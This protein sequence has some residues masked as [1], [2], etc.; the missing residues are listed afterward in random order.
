MESLDSIALDSATQ[1]NVN[2]W[3]NEPYDQETKAKIRELLNDNPQQIVDSFYTN[4]AFGT[5]GLRG[6][7]GVGTNRVNNY[8]VR[9]ATQGLA[10]YINS[11]PK[12][13]QEFSVFIGYDSRNQSRT[14]AEESAKVLAANQIRVYLCKHL[15]P[16]PLVSFGCRYKTCTAAIMITASHNPPE[17]NG[18][19]VYWN[20]GA[21]VLSPHDKGIIEEVNKITGPL[22]VNAVDSL[23]N[24]LIKEVEEEIDN[25][26]LDAIQ[27]LQLHPENNKCNGKN[28]SI[29]YTSL[30]GTGITL[31]PKALER[32]GFTNVHYV[33]KQ[34]IPDGNFP[35]AHSPNPEE[36]AA[37]KLGIETMRKHHCDLLI[38]TDPDADRVGVVVSH[39]GE[40]IALN[41]NQTAAICL[42]HI[43]Q[44]LTLQ[45]CMPQKGAFIK[46]IVTTELFQAIC[47]NYQKPCFNVLP[48]FKYIGEY[49]RN[50]EKDPQG[51]QYIFGGEES[52]GYLLG[53][54]VRDKDAI[55]SSALICEAALIAK[56]E[57]KTLVDKLNDLFYKYGVY[58]EKLVSVKFPDSKEGKED[59]QEGMARLRKEGL[60]EINGIS[61]KTIEDYL[62]RVRTYI[63]TGKTEP[64]ALPA[65]DGLSF[66]LDDGSKVTIRPSGTEAKVKLYCGVVKKVEGSIEQ[67][68]ELCGT[69][70]DQLLEFL[71]NKLTCSC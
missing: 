20:D 28:L 48:G 61:V 71:K 23:Q 17:Y 30:H 13:Q 69:H 53:T 70:A 9:A 35:T 26:Y 43:C 25:P 60:K 41:G 44:A 58:E 63:S 5:G 47:D 42:E 14:F 64:I 54:I 16:T 66:W 56:Q 49:I 68:K 34:I 57:G 38:A 39:K 33:E 55:S 15:R 59:M 18:Y 67:T 6:I 11:Q 62:S 24:A 52:Y 7:M 4:L 2:K 19:K 8:T 32:C 22:L 29:A 31:M 12:D 3:L 27:T 45:N 50:W 1:T 37:L 10:N 36:L 40:P 51:F 65:S 21:Q 46:S